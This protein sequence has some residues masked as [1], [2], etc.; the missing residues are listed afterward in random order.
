MLR[1]KWRFFAFATCSMIG[2][3]FCWNCTCS[4][5]RELLDFLLGILAGALQF[6]LQPLHFLRLQRPRG[7]AQHRA[8]LLQLLLGSLEL[9]LLAL[10]FGSPLR[11]RGP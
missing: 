5:L 6:G 9:L 4:F 8:T 7:F 11:L 3:S 1:M 10:E 2:S